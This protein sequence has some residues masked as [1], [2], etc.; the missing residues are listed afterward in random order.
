ML[1]PDAEQGAR[2]PS[3]LAL[4]FA[5]DRAM[6]GQARA[7]RV[8]WLLVVAWLAALAL[9][10]SLSVRV[11]AGASTLRQAQ[12]PGGIGAARRLRWLPCASWRWSTQDR[13]R[14]GP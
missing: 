11:D 9:A 14:K 13:S 5:P 12:A 4:L 10:A 7:G 3:P 6:E 1:T 8:G 2:A